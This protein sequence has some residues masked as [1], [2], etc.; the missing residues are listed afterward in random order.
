MKHAVPHDL[1]Q[2]KAKAVADAAFDS[3]KK[4]LAKYSPQT[5][6]VSDRRANISFSVK[7]ISLRGALEVT[8]KSI[9][10]EL[11]VPFL[12]RPFQGKALGVIE[13]EIRQWVDKAKAG[14][15]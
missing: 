8:D 5:E 3:Y 12:L 7:G 9:D 11:D 4:R 1:G 14:E 2:A 10:M 13:Q 6:W 15:V